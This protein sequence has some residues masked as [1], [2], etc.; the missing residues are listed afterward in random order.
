[1]T[2]DPDERARR[3]GWMRAGTELFQRTLDALDDDELAGASLLDG[4][5]RAHVVGH[6]ARNADALLNLLAWA[7]TG[8]ESPM[9]PSPEARESG[10][11]DSAARPAAELRL[12][13]ATSVARLD[14]AIAAMTEPQW[15]GG[16]RTAQGRAVTGAEVPWMRTREVWVH[17]VD[18]A[19]AAS[20]ADL[21]TDVGAALLTDAFGFAVTRPDCP[22]VTVRATDADFGL[23]TGEGGPLVEASLVQLLPWA[24]GRPGAPAG[25]PSLPRWL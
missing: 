17:A 4:W 16:V 14:A 12:E 7:R 21:P 23:A 24:L 22:P 1:M 9:Y 3:I 5:S 2:V 18:L 19:A 13:L 25:W 15:Q 6:L 8:V 20:F 11:R 10:I